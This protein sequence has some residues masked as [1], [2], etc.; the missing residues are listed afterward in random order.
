MIQKASEALIGSGTLNIGIGI[1]VQFQLGGTGNRLRATG[2]VAGM[3]PEEHLLIRIPTIPGILSRL[4]EG[5]SIVVRYVYDGN[6]Y[7]FSSTI[8][9]FIN[10]PVLIAFLAYPDT[11]EKLN[12]REAKRIPCCLPATVR[13]D[14][15]DY[16]AVIVDIS[17]G[18]S[19]VCLEEG[20]SDSS[21]LAIDQTVDM[22][23]HLVGVAEEQV[24]GCRIKNV[25]K[26]AQFFELGFQFDQQNEAVLKNVKEYLENMISHST[27]P[28]GE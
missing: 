8:V 21:S 22:S 18:G 23:F 4:N 17:L 11:V 9:T 28:Y 27:G 7:G 15:S 24:I 6:V 19:R 20:V 5:D 13:T 10:R 12:L 2:V 26:D 3:T 25:K 14:G 16:K 1:P